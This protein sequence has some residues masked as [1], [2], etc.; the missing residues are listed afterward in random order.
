MNRLPISPDRPFPLAT[1]ESYTRDQRFGTRLFNLVRTVPTGSPRLFSTVTMPSSPGS[2]PSSR[3]KAATAGRMARKAPSSTFTRDAETIV[4][5][6]TEEPLGSALRRPVREPLHEHH[7][8]RDRPAEHLRVGAHRRDNPRA[9]LEPGQL[10]ERVRAAVE[11]QREGRHAA[12]VDR[13]R[14]LVEAHAGSGGDLAPDLLLQRMRRRAGSRRSRGRGRGR[15]RGSPRACR[16]SCAGSA[17]GRLRSRG[18]PRSREQSARSARTASSCS[19]SARC[20]AQAIAISRSSMSGLARASGSAWS[21]FADERR[22]VRSRG[23]RPRRRSGRRAPRR[24]EPCAGPRRRRRGSPR[25]GSG[26]PLQEH[27]A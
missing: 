21:G 4:G 8:R 7:V 3:K 25:P 1:R 24:R 5:T 12:A 9:A 10:G 15:R 6:G 19:G 2:R 13:D 26:R 22:K 14:H 16:S 11:G 18:R 23:R 27:Y 17:T 20:E